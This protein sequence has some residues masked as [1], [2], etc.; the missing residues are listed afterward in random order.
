MEIYNLCD[1]LFSE[2]TWRSHPVTSVHT[3]W[4]KRH[5]FTYRCPFWSKNQNFQTRPQ[6]LK[7]T[8]IWHV[9]GAGQNFCSILPVTL[10]I[11]SGATVRV[12]Y[13]ARYVHCFVIHV[14]LE[15]KTRQRVP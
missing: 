11:R 12:I 7:T 13:Y 10:V 15:L 3:I 6:A 2:L 5:E 1:F 14:M 8:K 4:L 9:F